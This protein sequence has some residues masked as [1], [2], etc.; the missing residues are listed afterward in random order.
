MPA[1]D[2]ATRSAV[3]VLP[4][5]ARHDQLSAVANLEPLPHVV[6]RSLLVRP[7]GERFGSDGQCLRF[8]LREVGPLDRTAGEVGEVQHLAGWLQMLDGL[9]GGVAP[10][11]TGIDN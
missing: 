1:S 3:K 4:V 8:L 9:L 11:R 10:F 5:P 7:Q 6:E 2:S